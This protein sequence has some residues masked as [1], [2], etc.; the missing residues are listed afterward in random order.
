MTQFR[1]KSKEWYQ[2]RGRK[3]DE[4]LSHVDVSK[5]YQ[6]AFRNLSMELKRK[7]EKEELFKKSRG[8]KSRE[9]SGLG[10]Y[11]NSFKRSGGRAGGSSDNE[12]Q[13]YLFPIEGS[14]KM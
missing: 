13:R 4:D 8:S 6:D 5:K 1:E 9:H 7:M 2:R 14:K 3:N 11:D 12:L 10:Q